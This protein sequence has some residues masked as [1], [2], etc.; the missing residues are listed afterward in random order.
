MDSKLEIL[1]T[2]HAW[3]EKGWAQFGTIGQNG[4]VR[5]CTN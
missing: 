4:V 5:M 2:A 3:I 1:H